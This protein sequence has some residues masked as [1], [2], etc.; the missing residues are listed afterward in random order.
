MVQ[1][2]GKAPEEG[3]AKESIRLRGTQENTR[4]ENGPAKLFK[5]KHQLTTHTHTQSAAF[6]LPNTLRPFQSNFTL[7][8]GASAFRPPRFLCGHVFS[9]LVMAGRDAFSRSAMLALYRN[10]LRLHKRVLPKVELEIMCVCVCV[11]LCV[12]VFYFLSLCCLLK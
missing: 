6:F 12:C 10:V 4:E 7:F 2:L 9:F 3:I 8:Q 1:Y 11:C 5:S